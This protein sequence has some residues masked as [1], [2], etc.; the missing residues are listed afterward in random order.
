MT[1][2]P[3]NKV[4]TIDGRTIITGS[5]NFTK[6]AENKIH[7]GCLRRLLHENPVTAQERRATAQ[8]AHSLIS[9][10]RLRY[11]LVTAAKPH[12]N[13]LTIPFSNCAAAGNTVILCAGNESIGVRLGLNLSS[14]SQILVD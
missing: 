2:T 5:F 3:H 6:A 9:L 7:D 12:W 4:I 8:A 1:D 14:A 13:S 11:L 10:R